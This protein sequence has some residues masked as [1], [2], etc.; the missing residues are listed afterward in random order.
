M[1]YL[2]K[3]RPGDTDSFDIVKRSGSIDD[4]FA[5]IKK[6]VRDGCPG[7]RLKIMQPVKYTMSVNLEL[8]GEDT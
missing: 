4:I 3:F 7:D 5:E 8:S 6:R 2:C 1:Y